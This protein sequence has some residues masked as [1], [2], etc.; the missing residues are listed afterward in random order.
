MDPQQ[1]EELDGICGTCDG[2]G[3]AGP[4]GT[5][6]ACAPASCAMPLKGR[7]D[8]GT[9]ARSPAAHARAHSSKI[10]RPQRNAACRRTRQL[11]Q[12]CMLPKRRQGAGTAQSGRSAAPQTPPNPSLLLPVQYLNAKGSFQ[13]AHTVIAEEKNGTKTTL[14]ADKIVVAVGG[15][16]KYPGVPGKGRGTLAA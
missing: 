9:D 4:G 12:C 13:D 1:D 11:L 10:I 8:A 15:R 2:L 16:P 7:R 5:P 6:R 3:T 14:T